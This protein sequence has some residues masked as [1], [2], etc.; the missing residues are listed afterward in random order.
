MGD[1]GDRL[2]YSGNICKN[3]FYYAYRFISLLQDN[4]DRL[5]D[6]M[7]EENLDASSRLGREMINAAHYLIE[8]AFFD[9]LRKLAK[10]L[11]KEYVATDLLVRRIIERDFLAMGF[12][13]YKMNL[14]RFTIIATLK[15]MPKDEAEF[16]K[17]VE[18]LP[19]NPWLR[20]AGIQAIPRK[21]FI[22]TY[23]LPA[24]SDV[25]K[26]EEKIRSHP[27]IDKEKGVEG[28]KLEYTFYTKP[29][30]FKEWFR[31]GIIM[32]MTGAKNMIQDILERKIALE[33]REFVGRREDPLDVEDIVLMSVLEYRYVV[34]PAWVYRIRGPA[35]LGISTVKYHF[36]RHIKNRYYLG[37]YLKRPP[38]PEVLDTVAVI[39]AEGR[40]VEYLAY[41][42][43]R[44]PY[45][46]A[47]CNYDKHIC[48]IQFFCREQDL[49][50]I[51]K[52]LG[53][54]GI[55]IDKV[56]ITFKRNEPPRYHYRRTLSLATYAINAKKWY[57]LDQALK[58]GHLAEARIIKKYIKTNRVPR[59]NIYI[60][61]P[62]ED[63]E[64][65]PTEQI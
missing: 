4:I 14:D 35:K 8:N 1:V 34:T 28:Y 53:S 3:T 31:K 45:A 58:Y 64:A 63:T 51:D 7:P 21:T 18:T 32:T 11:G 59:E 24:E 62:K 54:Q 44:T 50:F 12:S 20:Y 9:D 23:L 52:L 37:I 22:L 60:Y 55:S 10:A 17:L 46:S 26:I 6:D 49:S 15:E 16:R 47:F 25:E 40:G 13:P 19:Y 29:I 48:S 42:L 43:S 56:M 65:E 5:G 33:L 2:I 27:A 61:T 38:N 57:K 39:I 41:K 36:K 30:H